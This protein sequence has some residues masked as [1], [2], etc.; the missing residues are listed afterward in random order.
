MECNFGEGCFILWRTESI[1]A[2]VVII[3]KGLIEDG[4]GIL[5]SK[6]SLIPQKRGLGTM[7]STERWAHTWLVEPSEGAELRC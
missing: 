6:I 5:V 3:I 4:I 7:I 2:L 1:A